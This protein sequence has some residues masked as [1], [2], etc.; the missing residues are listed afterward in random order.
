LSVIDW[1]QAEGRA[2]GGG[3]RLLLKK[4]GLSNPLREQEEASLTRSPILIDP[5]LVHILNEGA[6]RKTLIVSKT[7]KIK[8]PRGGN[9]TKLSFA[10]SS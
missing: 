2:A 3:R 5:Q 6:V 10:K 7:L 9:T 8:R 4:E 1:Q